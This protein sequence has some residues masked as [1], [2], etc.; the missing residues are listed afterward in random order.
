[1]TVVIEGDGSATISHDT[2][3]DVLF[4]L[5]VRFPNLTTMPSLIRRFGEVSARTGKLSANTMA[6]PLMDYAILEP[7]KF[8]HLPHT[9]YSSNFDRNKYI[10]L[11]FDNRHVS[12][13]SIM[14][15]YS[16]FWG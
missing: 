15:G 14:G 7:I 5:H 11:V 4:G 13:N 1:M 9:S 10:L 2:R 6:K 12:S 3:Q 16:E 8:H